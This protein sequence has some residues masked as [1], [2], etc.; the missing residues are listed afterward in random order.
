MFGARLS[1]TFGMTETCGA[2]LQT[3]PTDPDRI[4]RETV[5]APLAGT[6]VRIAGPDGAPVPPGRGR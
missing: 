2:V 3:A 6:D 1:I 4:R 5:G